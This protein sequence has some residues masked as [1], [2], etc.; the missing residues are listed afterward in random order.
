MGEGRRV[1]DKK[2]QKTKK[3]EETPL[4]LPLRRFP[5]VIKQLAKKI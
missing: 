4:P 2:K 1:E 3:S 5:P